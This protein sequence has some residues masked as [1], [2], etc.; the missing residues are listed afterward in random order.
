[1]RVQP[2][3]PVLLLLLSQKKEKSLPA[4]EDSLQEMNSVGWRSAPSAA[5]GK[6]DARSAEDQID[7]G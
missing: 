6:P 4:K 7:H 3:R 5:E 1:M 2:N